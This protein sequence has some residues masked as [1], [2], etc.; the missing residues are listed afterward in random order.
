M[1]MQNSRGR[2]QNGLQALMVVGLFLLFGGHAAAQQNIMRQSYT[3]T[4]SGSIYQFNNVIA[5]TGFS[6]EEVITGS[7]STVSIVVQG[8][9][10]GGTCDTL[11]TY[12]TVANTIRQ[13]QGNYDNFQITASWTNGTNPT[14]TLNIL[15][16]NS[17][18]YSTVA[19]QKNMA[20]QPVPGPALVEKSGRWTQVSN[21]AAGS[22]GTASQAAAATGVHHVCDCIAFSA[23]ATTAPTLTALKIN[24]RDGASGAG[25]I[26]W[27]YQVAAA[28]ST[29]QL[30]APHSVCGLAIEGSAATAMTL[31]FSAGLANLIQSVL[32]SGYDVQ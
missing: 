23:V 21:P 32:I 13:I 26:I 12:T 29:G 25:N 1:R 15:V 7:P 17:S 31:E 19:T 20:S 27:T 6:L 14:V 2:I 30:V 5:V 18:T 22:Q 4:T 16:T 28:G 24:L 9:M 10:R 11:D 3:I 8:C